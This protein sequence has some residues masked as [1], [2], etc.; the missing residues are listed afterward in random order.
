MP[1]G[2]VPSAVA[3]VAGLLWYSRSAAMAATSTVLT[4]QLLGSELEMHQYLPKQEASD[5]S[6]G[7]EKPRKVDKRLTRHTTS[8]VASNRSPCLVN[9]GLSLSI[10]RGHRRPPGCRSQPLTTS[11]RSSVA[12]ACRVSCG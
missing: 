1:S 12:P 6:V 5:A 9:K 11:K 7:P 3:G 4:W 8:T 10:D 2:R